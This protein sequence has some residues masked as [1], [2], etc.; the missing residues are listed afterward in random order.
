VPL[1]H[2]GPPTA[3]QER[4]QIPL[5]GSAGL[6]LLQSVTEERRACVPATR[7]TAWPPARRRPPPARRP[8][9]RGALTAGPGLRARPTS[10]R[11]RSAPS[12]GQRATRRARPRTCEQRRGERERDELREEAARGPALSTGQR[13]PSAAG[14]G[15]PG[16]PREQE[17]HQERFGRHK[18]AE[19]GEARAAGD[20]GAAQAARKAHGGEEE[21]RPGPLLTRWAAGSLPGVHW[22]VQ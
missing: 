13:P 20:Q 5:Q 18:D 12:A 8:A 16:A 1:L 9:R 6:R 15:A 14:R 2:R 4:A 19:E 11:E 7:R 17:Q 3:R 22:T 21:A 10:A